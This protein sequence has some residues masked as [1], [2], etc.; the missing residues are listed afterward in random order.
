MR[1]LAALFVLAACK[2]PVQPLT[3]VGVTPPAITLTT[4]TN[5][6][7]ALADLTGAHDRSIVVFYRGFF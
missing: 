2:E 7:V 4:S 1:W 6:K 5:A 3:Q